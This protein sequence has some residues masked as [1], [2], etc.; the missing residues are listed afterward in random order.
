MLA[1]DN[2]THKNNDLTAQ[3]ALI[4]EMNRTMKK[5]TDELKQTLSNLNYANVCY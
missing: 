3:Q 4:K 5:E 1:N 2:L